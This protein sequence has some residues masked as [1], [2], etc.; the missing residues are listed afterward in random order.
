MLQIETSLRPLLPEVPLPKS[1]QKNWPKLQFKKDGSA[2]EHAKRY[3]GPDHKVY[4]VDRIILTQPM[5]LNNPEHVRDFLYSQ[6]WQPTEWNT[7]RD[8]S[9]N[10][11]RTTPKLTEDSFNT[12]AGNAGQQVALYRKMA[13]R[14]GILQGWLDNVRPDGRIPTPI[15]GRAASH[16]IRHSLVVNVP[17]ADDDVYFGREMREVYTCPEGHIL[18]G[19]DADACQLRTLA[20]AMYR[21]GVGDDGFAAA[22]VSGSKE[23]GTD[24]HTINRDRIN[25]LLSSAVVTRNH[26]KNLT[27]GSIFGAG[28]DKIAAMIGCNLPLAKKILGIFFEVM[29]G[30][31]PLRAA[32]TDEYRRQGFICGLD[33]RRLYGVPERVLLVDLMQMDETAIM[34]VAMCRAYQQIR[35]QQLRARQ[36]IWYHDEINYE[37]ELGHEQ[38]VARILADS[39]PWAGRYLQTRVPFKG[40]AKIGSNWAT[41]H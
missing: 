20:E 11:R 7:V 36:L 37:V 39:I 4:R 17:K 15:G 34:E 40:E 10:K 26:T 25:N 23:S 41:V 5:S 32:L 12:I 13:S 19:A 8:E 28:P 29:P 31:I 1:K 22:V 18:V 9:G 2:S 3:Y 6:G 35:S 16:R 27:F 21:Y 24:P 38:Q 33:G 14:L 30:I